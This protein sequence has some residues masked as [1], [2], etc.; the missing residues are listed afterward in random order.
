MI[1]MTQDFNLTKPAYSVNDLLEMLPM[2]RTRLYASIK[3]G[4]LKP[5]K[6]GKST[7]FFAKDVAAFLSKIGG[8]AH[9]A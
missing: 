7:W 6:Y 9:V 2:G 1:L 5:T 3:C 8:G 4:D